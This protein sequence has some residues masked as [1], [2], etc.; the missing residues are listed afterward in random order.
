M[1]DF[2]DDLCHG[3][4]YENE[5]EA[6]RVVHFMVAEGIEWDKYELSYVRWLEAWAAYR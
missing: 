4:S 5:M 2:F 3:T 1:R 6:N